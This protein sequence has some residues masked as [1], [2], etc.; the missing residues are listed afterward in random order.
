[1]KVGELVK[2]GKPGFGTKPGKRGLITELIQYTRYG[3]ERGPIS[4]AIVLF[5]TG[6]VILPLSAL[7]RVEDTDV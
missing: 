7:S 5:T 1:M 2:V 3:N 4:S 6:T